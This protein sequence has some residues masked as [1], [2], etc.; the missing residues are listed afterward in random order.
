M[1]ATLAALVAVLCCVASAR[2]LAVAVAPT[3]LDPKLLLDALSREDARTWPRIRDTLLALGVPWESDVV[4]AFTLDSEAARE[5]CLDEQMLELEWRSQ[6]LSRV[7][8]VCASIATSAGF[9]FAS[10]AV[11]HGLSDP[12]PDTTRTLMTALNSLTV[13]VAGMS[14]CVAVH[15]RARRVLRE[16]LAS[17]QRLIGRFRVLAGTSE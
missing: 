10:V 2:R 17:I 3:S 4:A 16:R 13:G 12:E 5:A 14:F 8:R 11:L 15:L 9:L 1:L 6:R 7:P